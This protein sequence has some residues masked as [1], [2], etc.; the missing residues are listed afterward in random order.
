MEKE[1]TANRGVGRALSVA[2]VLAV[3]FAVPATANA[4]SAVAQGMAVGAA[5]PAAQATAAQAF[6]SP[7]RLLSARPMEAHPSE[8]FTMQPQSAE[9]TPQGPPA[10][11]A[12]SP[13]TVIVQ[14]NENNM[15]HAPVNLKDGIARAPG[16]LEE[17]GV[18]PEFSMSD[19][20]FTE[21]RVFP[22]SNGQ[23]GPAVYGEPYRAA[24]AL[25]FHDPTT[26]GD[27]ICSAS[28][29]SPRL[30]LTAGHC[31]AHGST[32]A[33]QRYFYTNFLFI[34]AY[35]NGGAPYGTWGWSFT[36]TTADWF[37]NG[38][39]PNAH[40][41]GIIEAAD[42]GNNKVGSIVGWLGWET[43]Q[44]AFNHFTTLGYPCNLDSC[45]LMQKNDAQ[46]FA[47]GGNNT[48]IQGTSMRGGASGGPW[49]QDFGIQPTGAPAV[50]FGGN[51]VVGVTSYGPIATNIGY[52]GASQF[53]SVFVSL[54]SELCA[55]KA[56]NC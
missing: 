41:F 29:I 56:G 37:N 20:V 34:P 49:I 9:Q 2:S 40:D 15:V 11:A 12:G 51:V 27:F 16:D 18:T 25:F 38:N 17:S 32:V 23:S 46:T 26:G 36:N 10:G 39:V 31:V 28:M 47:F 19:G 53:D 8:N 35:N 54:L 5:A 45:L 42:Q 4:Q 48:W 13:P 1:V 44:L 24:G 6:W 7:D 50:P 3:L 55:H 52:L 14:P 33:S 30:I 21:S 22:P 43:G